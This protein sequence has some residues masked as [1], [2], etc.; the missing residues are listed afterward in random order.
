MLDTTCPDKRVLHYA[1]ANFKN[2]L[3]IT[4]IATQSKA[5]LEYQA[6][7]SLGETGD[8]RQYSFLM[9]I[10]PGRKQID[11]LRL[12]AQGAA[13][14]AKKFQTDNGLTDPAAGVGMLVKLGGQTNCDGAAQP[15]GAPG[16]LS[17]VKPLPS[18]ANAGT[19]SPAGGATSP[20]AAIPTPSAGAQSSRAQVTSASTSRTQRASS[21][22]NASPTSASP[23]SND[24]PNDTP[25]N[26]NENA[27]SPSGGRTT[28]RIPASSVLQSD[29]LVTST[30][31]PGG[32]AEASRT[33][34]ASLVQQ[35]TNAALKMSVSGYG[36]LAP[37]LAAAGVVVW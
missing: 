21:A 25:D 37:L 30:N 6:P 14:D 1:R 2:N 22:A 31:V 4:N 13:F 18:S 34:S 3:D 24:T 26:G 9:Y 12:P 35:S 7:G 15:S 19:T 16:S 28:G 33:A 17:S 20:A 23:P 27:P 36:L 5:Q 32:G 10:N 11:Q 8:D 29:G